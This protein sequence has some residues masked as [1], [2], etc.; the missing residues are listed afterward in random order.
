MIKFITS[1][2]KSLQAAPLWRD[3]SGN[4]GI[5]TAVLLPCLIGTAGVAL[6]LVSAL[7]TK[8]RMGEIADSASLAATSALA[9]KKANP[10]EAKK[11]ATD[12][13]MVQIGSLGLP[14]DDVDVDVDIETLPSSS[15]TTKYQVSV[16]IS[17]KMPTT[18][19][20]VLGKETMDVANTSISTGATGSQNSLSMYLVLDR[21]GSM[22][23]SVVG[24]VNPAHSKCTYYYLNAAQ[25]RMSST[26]NH[27]PCYYQRIEV[28]KMAV[29]DLLVTLQKT[30]PKERLIRT[31]AGGFSSDAFEPHSLEWG[32]VGTN[33]HVQDMN[34]NG[35]TSSTKA[36]KKGVEA[37]LDRDEDAAHQ[38]K[39]GLKPKKYIVFM[40]DGEN[41]HHSDNNSTNAQC[42]HA[43][44]QNVTVYTVGFMLSS[45][46][47]KEFLLKCATSS[48]HYFD[49]TNGQALSA[50]FAKIAQETSGK[51]PLLTN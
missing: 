38:A 47:A 10:S 15:G 31:G 9:A 46:T 43:K 17:G 42:N 5:M 27:S 49:A 37:L 32:V 36:F 25:T 23:A 14:A 33:Q 34:A 21:S 22:E 30:D 11:L 29:S 48:N 4:F 8:G 16:S 12:F 35:G 13:A 3:T 6:D 7:D 51:L 1:I 2:A 45:P 28:M 20:Q 26:R 50:A 24:S 39:N 18:L 44:A 40:T 19:L 41:N